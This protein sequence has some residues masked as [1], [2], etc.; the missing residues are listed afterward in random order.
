MLS[1]NTQI[2]E[3]VDQFGLWL[4]N[5]GIL[6]ELDDNYLQPYAETITK[7]LFANPTLIC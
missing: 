4:D 6:K 7:I 1:Q 3:R 5:N 2:S